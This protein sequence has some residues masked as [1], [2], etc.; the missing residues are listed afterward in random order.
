MDSLIDLAP[1]QLRILMYTAYFEPEYSGAALQ[2]LT[3]ARELRRRGH[4]IEFVTNRWPGLDDETLVDGFAVR[5]LE[6]GR[7][8]KHREFRLWLNLARFVWQRRHDFDILHSHGAYYTH[9]FIGPLAWLMGMK[10]LVKASLARDDLLG[11]SRP[12]VGDLHRF[13]LRRVSACVGIS[14]DLVEEFHVGGIAPHRIHHIPNGVD[15]ERFHAVSAEQG[16]A[17]RTKLDL[18][19]TR[20]IVLYVG[21]LDPRKNILW[22]AE[23]WVAHDG[24][25]TGALLLAV[26][27]QGRD[28]P[29]GSLRDR[30]RDIADEH[31]EHFRLHEFHADVTPYYQC[32]DLLVLP[33]HKEGLPNVVLEAMACGLPC[34]AAR[35]SGSR[36]LIT[37]GET[38]RTYAVDDVQGLAQAVLDCLGPNGAAMGRHARAV[39]HESYSIATVADRYEVLYPDLLGRAGP[40]S[41]QL[42]MLTELFLPTKGGTAVMFEDDCRRLGGRG[43]HVVTAAVAGAA[44]FDHNHPNAVHRLKLSRHPWL[45]PESLLM[46]MRLFGR[47]MH[48]ALTR[49]FAAVMG[50]RALPEGITAWAIGRLS[51]SRVV[52]YAHGEELTGWGRGNKFRAMC[53]ALRRADKVLANSDFTRQTLIDLIGVRP[54]RI[55]MAFPTV[56]AQRFRPELPFADLRQ[57]LGLAEHQRLVLSVG[58]LQRRKGFDNVVRTLPSLV[59]QGLD[60]HYALVGIGEDWD[61]LQGLAE[62][63]GVRKRLHLLGHVEPAD[64]PRWYNACDL[65]AMP[66]RD[67]D[68]DTEGFG[69]VYLEANACAKPAIAG[70]AG[71]TGSAVVHGVNGLRVDGDS[72]AAIGA[73]IAE[74]LNDREQSMRLGLQARQR[75]LAEFTPASR[76][77]LI[78][79]VILGR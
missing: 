32:V 65:F 68:G 17:L 13:M 28:D 54:D 79:R 37:E 58:R 11:L 63:L 20:P 2:A 42:L 14:G 69:I 7:L 9:A 76:V 78:R 34:V 51:G 3:L 52:I 23:Q 48:L 1:R 10:S 12:I 43:V 44:E 6:P 24:F 5:R 33:S 30:L 22:L 50:G 49:R 77:E 73:A 25:G 67:I 53:F 47:S 36:E 29:E 59:K 75:I 27:P 4:Q 18:P 70:T 62:Q 16:A 57:Q 35:T 26:G 74:L 15:T 46:Y 19:A 71:G 45:R 56:D 60:V 66:N 38:G 40:Q 72:V 39:A 31:P 8:R 64:L 61:H 21:V 41:L 55:V